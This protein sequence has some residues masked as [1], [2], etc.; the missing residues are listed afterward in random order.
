MPTYTDSDYAS[1]L[2]KRRSQTSILFKLADGIISWQSRA[3]KTIAHSATEAEYMV[4]SNC[5]QQAIWI[6]N[7][8]SE[9]GLPVRPTPI[10]ADNEGAIFIASNPVQE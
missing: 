3:Q 4:L 10:C 5:S 2:I 1:D 7:I 8:F 9:L 6:Q